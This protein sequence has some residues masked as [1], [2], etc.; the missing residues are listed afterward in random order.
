MAKY[1]LPIY[2][3]DYEIKKTYTASICPWGLFMRAISLEE[4]LSNENAAGQMKAIAKILK[5][6]FCGLTDEDLS[7]ADAGD[8]MNTFVQICAGGEKING[9]NSKNV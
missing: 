9:G 8:V 4:K 1:E 7:C 2:G 3:E 6:L 5:D